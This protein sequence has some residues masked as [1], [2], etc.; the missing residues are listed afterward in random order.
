MNVPCSERQEFRVPR[1]G[2]SSP[3]EGLSPRMAGCGAVS[4]LVLAAADVRTRG[5]E[6]PAGL[7]EGDVLHP[8][9]PRPGQA[10]GGRVRARTGTCAHA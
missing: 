7:H 4:Q 6:D 1:G 3:R 2:G 5:G 10:A 8:Q 9:L